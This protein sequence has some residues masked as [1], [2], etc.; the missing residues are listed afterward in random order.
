MSRPALVRSGTWTLLDANGTGVANLSLEDALERADQLSQKIAGSLTRLGTASTA[1]ENAIKPISGSTQTYTNISKNVEATIAELEVL[2]SYQ[3]VFEEEEPRIRRGNLEVWEYLQ[4]IGRLNEAIKSLEDSRLKSSQQV[5]LKMKQLINVAVGNVRERYSRMLMEVSC[6][7]EP[8]AKGSFTYQPDIGD[9]VLQ[10]L[11][12]MVDFFMVT[13]MSA[14]VPLYTE[15]RR[16]YIMYYMSTLSNSVV[17]GEFKRVN[18]FYVKGSSQFKAYLDV[19]TKTMIS[20]EK[21]IKTIF[22]SKTYI[23]SALSGTLE[24]FEKYFQATLQSVNTVIRKGLVTDCLYAYDILELVHNAS[25]ELLLLNENP[26]FNL[27][28]SCKDLRK[29]GQDTFVEILRHIE[30]SVTGLTTMPVDFAVLDITRETAAFIVNLAEYDT[31]LVSLLIPLG[32]PR[33]WNT[34]L[35]YHTTYSTAPAAGT[36]KSSYMGTEILGL[37]ISECIDDLLINIEAKSRVQ[38]KKVTRVGLQVI[39]NLI[40]LERTI[41]KSRAIIQILTLHGFDRLEKIKNRALNMF[42]EGWAS[43][44]EFLMDKTIVRSN[45]VSS[46]GRTM[47]S[48]DREVIKEKFKNFNAL[49]DDLVAKFKEYKFTDPALRAYLAKEVAF[50]VP[51]YQRFYDK[52]KGG[53]F[54]KH[55]EKYIKYTRH[56]L[57]QTLSSLG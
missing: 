57:E 26:V 10:K 29:T 1:I 47:S 13:D 17:N 36:P 33:T 56:E 12:V 53:E 11:S 28:S 7:P 27:E 46:G 22:K 25:G 51:L 35:A 45:T 32:A 40:Y 52:H 49:F 50:I 30:V 55:T 18:G 21:A 39:S 2:R 41:R 54:S 20:E 15:I 31:T 16:K 5:T 8:R 37:F 4:S 24:D 6:I 34:R 48:K 3:V 43:A 19:I 23:Q 9:D 38:Y 14:A 42:L 44:A